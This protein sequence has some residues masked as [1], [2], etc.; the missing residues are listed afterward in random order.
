VKNY[1]LLSAL[2]LSLT[3]L[4]PPALAQE[5]DEVIVTAEFRETTLQSQSASTSIVSAKMIQQRAAQHLE[6][7]L[8]LA[9]NVNYA[10]GAS[11]SRFYQIRGVGE[12]SQFQEPLNPSIGFMIDGIDFSG[13][14]TAGTLFDVEQV[15]VLRGPQGTLYGANALAG[16]I[17]VRTG[18]PTAE[19]YLRMEASA[20]EYDSWSAGIVG[21]GPLIANELLYRL[22]VNSYHSD[23]YI[24]N[25][26]LGA[27]DTNKRDETS[28]RGKLRWLVN[29]HSTLDATALYIDVDNGYDAF[30]LDNTR[31]TLSDQPGHDLQESTA[32]GLKWQSSLAGVKLEI[33]GSLASSDTN[34]SYDEDWSFVGIAPGW[35]YSSTDQYLRDRDS[36]SAEVRLLSNE[37]TTLFNG[38]TD[39]VAGVYYLA[40]REDLQ[41]RYTFLSRDFLSEYDTDTVAIFGQLDSRLTERVTLITGLRL[42]NR[43]THYGDSNGVAED[44]DE[45]FWGGR[46]VLEYHLGD[47]AMLY[48]GVSRGYRANGVNAG[49]LASLDGD[50]GSDVKEQLNALRFYDE[51][52]L[53]NYEAGH[54]ATYFEGSVRT[55]LAVFYMDR[56]DQQVKGSLVIPREGGSTQ[57]IDYTSNAAEGNNYG[58]ELELDWLMTDSL[59][60][61]ANMGL[62]E[63]ELKNFIT[64]DGVDQSGREQAHAPSYQYAVGARYDFGGGFYL[65]GDLEGKDAFYFSDRHDVESPAQDLL[66]MRVGYSNQH[67]EL[68]LWGRN[69]TDE[70]YYARGFGSFGNDPRKEYALEPYYQYGEPRVI[71]VSASYTF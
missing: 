9:P 40:D 44:P 64:A 57:F 25:D 19:P 71:G 48:A 41:R 63:T 31:H 11:R 8:N 58:L 15:E 65:R 34:Y 50:N 46:I 68:A 35:E 33:A 21:S 53:L 39:W 27:D 4:H 20:A 38:A 56:K 28:I 69:L 18:Q 49:I 59:R 70:D 43:Q 26:Y 45:S 1:H 5:I 55:R 16:L 13:L 3:A 2:G 23:G 67:W 29:D 51:E 12:R 62:L 42:E 66:H 6:E 36:Y 47:D 7:I 52:Y 32:L 22:S 10:S 37:Q 17:N 54:K 60:V 14:G 24:E 61:Y 30:S